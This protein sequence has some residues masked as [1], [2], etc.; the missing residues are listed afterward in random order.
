LEDIGVKGDLEE[1]TEKNFKIV[2]R[3]YFGSFN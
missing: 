3:E 2:Q 1:I